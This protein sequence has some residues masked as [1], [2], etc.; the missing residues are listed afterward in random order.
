MPDMVYSILLTVI[1][2]PVVVHWAWTEDGFLYKL[3]YLDFAGSG[4]I[5][6]VGGLA[7]GIGCVFAGYRRGRFNKAN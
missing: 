3:G 2:Y 1:V 7:G 5:H 4:V 6:M